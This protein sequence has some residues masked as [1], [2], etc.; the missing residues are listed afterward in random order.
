MKENK[1]KSIL[2]I[3]VSIIIAI[4]T[5]TSFYNINKDKTEQEIID[6]ALNELK[7]YITTYNMTKK[8][9][10]ELSSKE[11]VEQ[12]VEDEEKVSAEQEVENESF[13][14]QR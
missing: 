9:I 2:L 13:E 7:G 8:E 6:S 1:K 5:A 12:T 11:I 3:V 14:L 4:L 10:E